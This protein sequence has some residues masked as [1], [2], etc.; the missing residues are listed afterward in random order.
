M[1]QQKSSKSALAITFLEMVISLLIF[2][3]MAVVIFFVFERSLAL[4]RASTDKNEVAQRAQ[5]AMEWIT[6]DVES[7]PTRFV[8]LQLA[9]LPRESV[10]SPSNII[11]SPT[12]SSLS[13]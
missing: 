3:F 8:P 13:R 10:N 4:Y 2:S 12:S 5:V 9:L 6:R 11:I 1:K 7:A